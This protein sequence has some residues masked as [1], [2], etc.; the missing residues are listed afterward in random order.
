MPTQIS[1]NALRNFKLGQWYHHQDYPKYFAWL[2]CNPTHQRVPDELYGV[3]IDIREDEIKDKPPGIVMELVRYKMEMALM[4]MESYRQVPPPLKNPF[5][6][7]E[8]ED[9]V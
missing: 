8:I 3:R 6:E 9:N 5:A 1:D 7:E 4:L 2:S